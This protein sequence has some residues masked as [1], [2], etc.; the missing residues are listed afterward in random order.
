MS[1]AILNKQALLPKVPYIDIK[2]E[3]I[4]N[5]IRGERERNGERDGER[6]I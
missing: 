2:G 5:E 4:L 3:G 1:M 6:W